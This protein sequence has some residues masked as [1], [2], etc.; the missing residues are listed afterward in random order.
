MKAFK[1][2]T[3]FLSL[4]MLL[5]PMAM[6]GQTYATLWKDVK[7]AQK[8]DLP[9]TEIK[10]L[11]QIIDK[12]KEERSFGNLLKAELRQ[13]KVVYGITPDS[14]RPAVERL[15]AVQQSTTEMI[16]KSVYLAILSK[17][18]A[19][20]TY[21]HDEEKADR[22]A[23][24]AMRFPY[25]LAATKA[26][27]FEPFVREGYNA[28]VFDDDLLSV[29]GHELERFRDLYNFYSSKGN[30]RAA[31]ISALYLAMKEGSGQSSYDIKKSPYINT[32][33]SIIEAFGDLDVAGE[34]A[35]ERY[36]GMLKCQNVKL[37]DRINYIHYALD[38]WG[39]W[40][41]MGELRNEERELTAPMFR[42]SAEGNVARPGEEKTFRIAKARNISELSLN[43]YRIKAEGDISLNP[44]STND[45][46]KIME[47]A[48]EKP[49]VMK[50][51]QYMGN[52]GYEIFEDSITIDPLPLGVYLIEVTTS[53]VTESCYSL[54]YVT[55]NFLL[56]Q[57][58][59]NNA[60]RYVAL[61]ATTGKP[62]AGADLRLTLNGGSGKEP[63]TVT[64]ACDEEGEVVYSY[65]GAIG[66]PQKAFLYTSEDSY[67]PEGRSG[68][69]FSFNA[70]D[71][72]E[73]LT[74]VFTDRKIYRP[75]Q[76]VH[77]A[78]IVYEKTSYVSAEVEATKTVSIS[79]RDANGNV[80]EQKDVVTDD[81]G[82]CTADFIL[83][84]NAL[85]GRF[86]VIANGKSS[87]IRV[88]QYKRPSFKVEF[89][90]INTRYENGDTLSIQAKAT[91]YS[92][93]PVQGA[94]VNYNVYRRKAL[95]WRGG[96]TTTEPYETLLCEATAIT[97]GDGRFG[98][99]VPLVMPSTEG[100]MFYNFC[101]EADVTDVS[102][103]THSGELS[104]P[105]GTR[106][107]AISSSIRDKEIADSLE[108]V[109]VYL[110]NNS[111]IDVNTTVRIRI[112]EGEWLEGRTMTP[113]P[114][115][116]KLSS[117]RHDLYALCDSDSLCQNFVVFSIDDKV[118]CVE[119]D[120]W[121]YI[122]STSFANDNTPVTLQVGSSANDVH[123]VYSVIAGE[124]VLESGTF[125]LD[126]SIYNRKLKY[127]KEYGNGLLLTF[128]WVK[129]GKCHTHLQ[130]I[131]MPEPDNTLRLKWTTFRDRLLPGDDE[132]W[133]LSI[134]DSK[135]KAADAQLMAT[136]YDKSLDQIIKHTWNINSRT[137]IP[138][139]STRWAYQW[140][141]NIS[142]SASQTYNKYK[143][144]NFRFSRFDQKV[145]PQA[146]TAA[147]TTRVARLARSMDVADDIDD[148]DD[149]EEEGEQAIVFDAEEEGT[150]HNEE[151]VRE[152]MEETAF[153]YPQLRTD[154]DGNV[155]LSFTLPETLTAW[156]FMG[157]AHTQGMA[158]GYMEDEAVAQK[159]VMAQPYMP[160]FVRIGDKSTITAKVFNTGN[161]KASGTV[162]IELSDP[163]SGL[164][165]FSDQQTFSADVN[166][167]VEVEFEYTP[168]FSD[169]MFSSLNPQPL[170]I[171]KVVASGRSAN[172]NYFSDG[173]QHYLPVLPDKEMVT[174]TSSFTQK[175]P[176][177]KTVDISKMFAVKDAMSKLTVEYTN[178]PMWMLLQ[179]LVPMSSPKTNNAID[180]CASMYA[181]LLAR[182][183][184]NKNPE[185]R[186]TILKWGEDT[187]D[188]SLI[189]SLA[190]NIEL[191][192]M[193]V[194]ETPWVVEAEM[195]SD[196]RHS[197]SKLFND[198]SI[199]AGLASA[200]DK[201]AHL[202]NPDGSWSWW[203]GMGGNIYIT[204]SVVEMLTRLGVLTAEATEEPIY[205]QMLA[206]AQTYLDTEFADMAERMMEDES[207]GR[208]Q[209]FPGIAALQYL[210]SNAISGRQLSG[211]ALTASDYLTVLLKKEITS[212]SIYEK[213]VTAIILYYGGDTAT[214]SDYV[215]SLKEYSV[216]SEEAGRYYA[217]PR[218]EYSWMD[219][220]IP[221]QVAAIEALKT[222]APHDEASI[223]EML[224]WLL[225]EKRT[226]A[227]DTPVNS[228][229]A[230]YA[231]TN[232]GKM[233]GLITEDADEAHLSID[234]V[235]LDM[236]QATAGIGY[237]KLTM[238]MHEG[239]PTTGTI[240][241]SDAKNFTAE[242]TGDGI[243]WGAIYAQFMQKSSDISNSGEGLSVK[244][245]IIVPK[246]GLR[247]GTRI[248]VRITITA[249]RDFD[250]V[251]VVDRKA[252]CMEPVEQLS[253]YREGAYCSP[254][255]N[256]TN[257]Y[258]DTF[259]KG[260]KVIETE[261]FISRAGTYET[262]TC[263]VSCAY[264][265]EY[266][267]TA[268]SEKLN[269]KD[270]E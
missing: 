57:A 19:G 176:G 255:D 120:D 173:E 205:G 96:V 11:Q 268:K 2:K 193:I 22:Y 45:L 97:D 137:N 159:E 187:D 221:T 31:C 88:E 61:S 130:K 119:T 58:L 106:P 105:L 156:R 135:G 182:H 134:T 59:P 29:V 213:A 202:Q 34:V 210:Y 244:R 211:K 141:K 146:E 183:I 171:C 154:D 53:P 199:K 243:S 201:L 197:L 117:G 266:R 122:S 78:A 26:S 206:K 177:M 14:L 162:R 101:V 7:S 28:S 35:V 169:E 198:V 121:F 27:E 86:S 267:A 224:L 98:V 66:K 104:I 174:V 76:T 269:V 40:Q 129:E 256:T 259:R 158:V 143:F 56:S 60:I 151:S 204:S 234:G 258:F 20:D 81:Y 155:V 1:V 172:G 91:S 164:V 180:Q 132:Q 270:K 70:T 114:L 219:Y 263:T 179:A 99:E 127:K 246:E 109:T 157:L 113:I 227:W 251:Q 175:G 63:S 16:T 111:G 32:L 191:K 125:S 226:Q 108:S 152:N 181:N 68:G 223:D 248:T 49:A 142:L 89:P 144:R 36:Y 147:Q 214:A 33:D 148:E 186:E 18:Y 67:Y 90:E 95:W 233:D 153:F 170:L 51:L 260:K 48:D 4:C 6:A 131:T 254:K 150:E 94:T 139:A 238:S 83:P 264:A 126:N 239:V 185:V 43:I 212:Q 25:L 116:N 133:C 257:Y 261:Y 13:M 167:T 12:A 3:F 196:Q 149:T 138:V 237:G 52:K 249:D 184:A 100:R 128:A 87:S 203:Q 242:K 8:K 42:L 30:R 38:R 140:K 216:Y 123:V 217:T 54:Y 262:G 225:Q 252:A 107:A 222:I 207:L 69:Y 178:N 79:L 189:S 37:E 265:P 220:R 5:L 21:L 228:V 229:N 77:V 209:T 80:V 218:A 188:N 72:K 163:E 10:L 253:G 93:M 208:V 73:E 50:R 62:L 235:A 115:S 9:E 192:D 161:A 24:E 124:K 64:L 160:R 195:E 145:F 194:E 23:E 102:G 74:Q 250:F 65:E 232:G 46:E 166:K 236:P 17:I 85:T 92:G 55:D 44:Q 112:D 231:F 41:R 136:L 15:E 200:A 240:I 39:A 165:V 247:I 71:G 82:T 230:V 47:K 103:E 118:P 241:S 245:E 84:E 190:R 75:G 215:K 110:K 168:T